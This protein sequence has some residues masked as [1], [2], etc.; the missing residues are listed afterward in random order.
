M[1]TLRILVVDDEPAARAFLRSLLEASA[2]VEVAGE[3]GDGMAAVEWLAVHKVEVVFLDIQMPGLDGFGVLNALK[4]PG[5]PAVVFVT[6]YD[7]FALK[8][9]EVEAW[10]YLLKPFDAERLEQ[11]LARVR[12]RLAETAPPDGPQRYPKRL[13]VPRGKGRSTV[14]LDQVEWIGAEANYARFHLGESS[15]LARVSLTAL[16]AKLD[17]RRFVR[18]HRSAIVNVDRIERLEPCGH[19]DLSLTLSGGQQLTLS[20]RFRGRLEAVL[21]SLS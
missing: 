19:G 15:Y 2:S 11:A 13:A 21:E 9:F 7:D 5:K 10:D 8:A 20:R 12:R 4:G 14:Q 17:P 1:K 16:E 18:I 6:A 3:C